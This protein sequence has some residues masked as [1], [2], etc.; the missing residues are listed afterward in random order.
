MSVPTGQSDALTAPSPASRAPATL[1]AGDRTI[2]SGHE[3]TMTDRPTLDPV[4]MA[5][6]LRADAAGEEG[7]RR[8]HLL[9][10]AGEWERTAERA[11][12]KPDALIVPARHA[13]V[14]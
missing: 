12:G 11:Q 14:A 6:A 7:P 10:L 2:G 1:G 4:A 3:I 5:Q 8:D 13:P 9:W